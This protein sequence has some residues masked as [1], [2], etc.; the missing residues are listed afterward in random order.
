MTHE[1]RRQV[2]IYDSSL[3]KGIG[4]RMF[5]YFSLIPR[6]TGGWGYIKNF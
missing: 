5:V 3:E 6:R 4:L 2:E 1:S